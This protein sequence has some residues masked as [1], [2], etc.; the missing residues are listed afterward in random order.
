MSARHEELTELL[1]VAARLAEIAARHQLTIASQ[2]LDMVQLEVT[3]A[4]FGYSEVDNAVAPTDAEK[5]GKGRT[6]GSGSAR[7]RRR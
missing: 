1:T 2:L 3:M 7:P 5:P 4:M 6:T